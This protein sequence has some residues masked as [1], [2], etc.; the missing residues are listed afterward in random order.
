LDVHLEHEY[1]FNPD[2]SGKVNV[3]WSGPSQGPELDPRTFIGEEVGK[4]KGVEAWSGVSYGQES[5][6][7]VFQGT[8]YFRNVSELR[9]H[10]QGL[11]VNSTDFAAASDEK[12][13]FTVVG[14]ITTSTDEPVADPGKLPA[15]IAAAR[16]QMAM[17]REFIEG[18][19]A[20]LRCSVI[21]RLPGKIKPPN[22]ARKL[23]D[24]SASTEMK[25]QDLLGII[26]KLMTDDALMGEMLRRGGGPDAIASLL[27]DLGPAEV[28][29]KGKTAPLFD[30]ET[31][32]AAAAAAFEEFRA[33][34]GVPAGPERAAPA[35][36]TRV[37]AAKLVR[38]A[39]GDRELH[40]LGQNYASLAVVVAGD[41]P[42]PALKVE[43]GRLEKF[44][45]ED[46]TDVT[47]SEDWDR[48]IHFPKLTK[49]GRTVFCEV[50]VKPDGE[51]AGIREI[52]GVVRV[53]V[54]TATEEVDLGFPA[55]EPGAQGTLFNAV[56]EKCETGEDGRVSVEVRLDLPMERI[57]SLAF[58]DENGGAAELNRGGYSSSGEQCSLT[59]DTD[60]ALVPGLRLK[61]RVMAEIKYYEVPFAVENVDLLGRP[62]TK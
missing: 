47:P 30:Y 32:V 19:F 5:D 58:V 16:E 28:S 29:T 25:G 12:G 31:E 42:G 37:V 24:N 46:G 4:A 48:R 43:E 1:F 14:R 52:R 54:A 35:T 49:D 3:R 23:D 59:L 36:N 62:R 57:L 26:D 7:A 41:L 6:R 38:E 50:E 11:H 40:P 18:M 33:S 45:L 61:A 51:P 20:G 10:C 44:V 13:G 9:F 2:G 34:L 55:L 15:A 53:Q 22:H 56:L 39:D 17:G 27:G 21:L 60:A 8:A